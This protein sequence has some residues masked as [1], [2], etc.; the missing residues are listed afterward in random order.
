MWSFL[1]K[2]MVIICQRQ[3]DR[4]W[5]LEVFGVELKEHVHFPHSL[6]EGVNFGLGA[7]IEFSS[8]PI[9]SWTIDLFLKKILSKSWAHPEWLDNG[10]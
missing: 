5:K 8:C 1:K 7:F 9:E 3:P 4:A 6:G 10:L 2:S